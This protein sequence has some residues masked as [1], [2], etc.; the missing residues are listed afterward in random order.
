MDGWRT[1]WY[2]W[3]AAWLW[4]AVAALGTAGC[5]P[6][7]LAGAGSGRSASTVTIHVNPVSSAQFPDG[8]TW[9]TA[10]F[11]L[12]EALQA[13][14]DGA[15][16]WLAPGIYRA[17][18]GNLAVG[19]IHH[20]QNLRIIGG[21]LPNDTGA[22][23][24]KPS[25]LEGK[26]GTDRL[27]HVLDVRHSTGISVHHVTVT[28]GGAGQNASETDASNWGGGIHIQDSQIKLQKV[29]C[30]SNQAHLG[31]CLGIRGQSHVEVLDS[32]FRDNKAKKSEH[33]SA[34]SV[35][36]EESAAAFWSWGLGG[37]VAV[38]EDGT[39]VIRNSE[40]IGNIASVKGGALYGNRC[41][42]RL[43]EGTK[44]TNNRAGEKDKI[45][46]GGAVAASRSRLTLQQVTFVANQAL[47]R[48]GALHAGEASTVQVESSE[49]RDNK[50]RGDAGA[51]QLD[52]GS[53][54]RITNTVFANNMAIQNAAVLQAAGNS[55]VSVSGSRFTENKAKNGFCAVALMQA[56]QW[57]E[58]E[59]NTYVDNTSLSDSTGEHPPCR[60]AP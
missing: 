36:D 7:P 6:S 15:E 41:H 48:G 17:P 46:E 55:S 2:V 27:L 29:T 23:T 18:A 14:P 5:K 40:F 34:G 60:G 45:G 47:Q 33:L 20:R 50:A 22:E 10:F 3:R 57:Q 35:S 16:I 8:K 44:F 24:T 31:G 49:F 25:V 32:I 4:L 12:A 19:E 39:V 37:A 13:A 42:L 30:E 56:S 54:L 1:R 38:D 28:G 58:E 21:I 9:K 59:G 26:R 51:V 11:T 53:N 43:E 52:T